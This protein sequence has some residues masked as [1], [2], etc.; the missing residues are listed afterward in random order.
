M[1][2]RRKTIEIAA[3][4]APVAWAG[5]IFA[6]SHSP[7]GAELPMLV[8]HFDKVVHAVVYGILSG[9]IA[10]A[11]VIHTRWPPVRIAW[12]ALLLASF[13]GMTDEFHQ[14][15]VPGR[16]TELLDWVAN[17]VGASWILFAARP[18]AS[19]LASMRQRFPK[20]APS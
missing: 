10:L 17:T 2:K 18:P 4:L 12:I 9:C 8:P 19:W 6:A 3:A 15:F 1:E 13:Y 7:R 20:D 11:L 16:S 14:Y 5:L